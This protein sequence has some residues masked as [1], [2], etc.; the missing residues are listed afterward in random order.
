MIDPITEIRALL[1]QFEQSG[2]QDMYVRSKDWT[3]FMA[4]KG[5][6]INPI[7]AAQMVVGPDKWAEISAPHLG[8]FE[9]VC[10]VGETVSAGQVIGLLDVLGRKTEIA[11]AGAGRVASVN[12][13]AAELVEFGDILVEIAT[14]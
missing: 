11:S 13:A 5:G 12:F 14:V 7:R 10:A 4:Q 9:L 6:A 8:L 1:R 3:V 2:L